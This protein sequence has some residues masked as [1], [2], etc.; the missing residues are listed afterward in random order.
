MAAITIRMTPPD[1]LERLKEAPA[2]VPRAIAKA[3]DVQNQ[4]TV[5]HII[6]H[7]MTGQGPFPVS[8]GRLGVRTGRL[9]S[10]L[11]ASAAVVNGQSITA[12]IGSNVKYAGAHEFGAVTK[13]HIIKARPGKSLRFFL[14]GR[15]IFRKSVK[16]PGSKI[17]ARQPIYR[18]IQDRADAYGAALSQAALKALEGS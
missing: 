5:D 8:E 10:S 4:L 13:P 12:A 16:H 3:M 15:E 1:L 11:R 17:P 18:G 9:R 6:E 7:R 14:G 2:S